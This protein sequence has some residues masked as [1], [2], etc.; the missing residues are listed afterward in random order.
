MPE[1]EDLGAESA[2]VLAANDDGIEDQADE[3]VEEVEKHLAIMAGPLP[4]FGWPFGE[5]TEPE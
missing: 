3:R 4:A 2:I 5:L 1:G